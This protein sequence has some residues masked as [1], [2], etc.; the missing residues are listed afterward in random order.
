MARLIKGFHTFV[1][2][3]YK[4]CGD[5]HKKHDKLPYNFISLDDKIFILEYEDYPRNFIVDY[6][7]YSRD[8]KELEL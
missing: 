5:F 8:F 4:R 6:E 1:S 2:K 7:N 3:E